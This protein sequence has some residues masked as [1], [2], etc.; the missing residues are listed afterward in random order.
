MALR[1]FGEGLWL[2]R[3]LFPKADRRQVREELR[4]VMRLSAR[5][6]D[7]DIVMGSFT[8]ATVAVSPQINYFFKMSGPWPRRHSKLPWQWVCEPRLAHAGAG[9]STCHGDRIVRRDDPGFHGRGLQRCGRRRRDARRRPTM[10]ARLHE[11]AGGGDGGG[12][13]PR[14]LLPEVL[15]QYLKLGY[16]LAADGV[17]PRQLHELRLATKH[18]R[19]GVEMFEPL[20]GPK[21]SE[22]LG[23]VRETQQA[24]G[25]I[26]DATASEAWLRS[27]RDPQRPGFQGPLELPGREGRQAIRRVRRV[28][29]NPLGNTRLRDRWVQYLRRYAGRSGIRPTTQ[30]SA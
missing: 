8:L 20:F 3:R 6:R 12:K 11:M 28:L 30:P 13:R 5:V 14:A 7:V 24:P 18:F 21:V 2:F 1:R 29:E 26:S 22:L 25:E 15:L 19:Y 16:R 17:H 9:P 27:H 23:I 4:A 10:E